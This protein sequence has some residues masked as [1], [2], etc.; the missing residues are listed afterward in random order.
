MGWVGD[1]GGREKKKKTTKN[2]RMAVRG[3]VGTSAATFRGEGKREYSL[4]GV[5]AP[6]GG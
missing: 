5:V 1:G 3:E 6:S 4:E 2:D